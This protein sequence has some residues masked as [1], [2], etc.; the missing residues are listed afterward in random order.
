M[1]SQ[2]RNLDLSVVPAQRGQPILVTDLQRRVSWNQIQAWISGGDADYRAIQDRL[3]RAA[4][5]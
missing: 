1:A 5:P 2:F 3:D 4:A